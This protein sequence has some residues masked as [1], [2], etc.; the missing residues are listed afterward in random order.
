M[1]EA[2]ISRANPTTYIFLVDQSGSMNDPMSGGGS[3]AQFVADVI[4]RTL[5][6]LVIRCTREEGVRDYFEVG[7][8]GYGGHGIKNGFQGAL[9]S[10]WLH[11]ISVVADNTLRVEERDRRVDDGAGGVITQKVKFPVWIDPEGYLGTPMQAAI[12]QCAQIIADWSD[13]HPK[14]FPATVLHITDGESTDG[15]PEHNAEILRSLT[16]DDGA[17][18]LYNIHVS[19]NGSQPIR[20]PSSTNEL[21]DQYSQLLFNMSSIFPQHVREYADAAH[22]M[23]L[24]ANSRA[25]VLNADADELV[26]FI[27]IGSRPAA[28]R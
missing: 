3:K 24:G 6:D 12:A 7:I 19:G 18:L 15:N 17:T 20:Y 13:A 11:P 1:Y 26:K 21:P 4:N 16:T 14:S 23:S 25:M 8:I 2:E 5:R 10:S 27:D 22:G 28:M 9:G